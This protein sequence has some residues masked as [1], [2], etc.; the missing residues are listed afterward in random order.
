MARFLRLGARRLPRRP[1]SM[2]RK[3]CYLDLSLLVLLHARPLINGYQYWFLDKDYI[4]EFHFTRS[5]PCCRYFEIQGDV[6]ICST[7]TVTIRYFLL[8]QKESSETDNSN[9][10]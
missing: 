9:T 2:Q 5:T 4:H 6:H 3:H 1:Q 10:R 7:K 8:D